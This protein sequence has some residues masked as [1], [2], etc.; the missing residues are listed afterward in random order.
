[1]GQP[2][3]VWRASLFAAWETG[4]VWS[5]GAVSSDRL[6]ARLTVTAGWRTDSRAGWKA[7]GTVGPPL[8]PFRPEGD[9]APTAVVAMV[10]AGASSHYPLPR[11]SCP[12]TL[13]FIEPACLFPV[14]FLLF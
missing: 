8:Q 1:M 10:G 4:R 2:G 12:W 14:F 11:D 5:R 6:W 7:G 9:V 13:P 3:S